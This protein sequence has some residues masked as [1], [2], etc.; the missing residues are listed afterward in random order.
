MK[1]IR[2][3]ACGR[4]WLVARTDAAPDRCP[5]AG[6][7]A[8]LGT[9][10]GRP[11]TTLDRRAI[12]RERRPRVRAP[13]VTNDP[14]PPRGTRGWIG[15]ARGTGIAF[16]I[17]AFVLLGVVIVGVV[18]RK[19]PAS[20]GSDHAGI[21]IE[22]VDAGVQHER[23]NG[24]VAR[25][26]GKPV[27]IT[28]LSNLRALRTAGANRVHLVPSAVSTEP[29]QRASIELAVDACM[30]RADAI[31][32]WIEGAPAGKGED[33]WAAVGRGSVVDLAWWPLPDEAGLAAVEV[34]EAP[35]DGAELRARSSMGSS[36]TARCR[37]LAPQPAAIAMLASSGSPIAEPGT[38]WFDGDGAVAALTVAS[39]GI[40]ERTRRGFASP[41]TWSDQHVIPL[42]G[43]RRLVD[44]MST[45]CKPLARVVEAVEARSTQP[46][47]AERAARTQ[48]L[49]AASAA[50]GFA[51]LASTSDRAATVPA[52][53]TTL[54][55]LPRPVDGEA[56]VI[57][58]PE[59]SDMVD[60]DVVSTDPSIRLVAV[61]GVMGRMLEVRDAGGQPA[62]L[63]A[64]R[65]VSISITMSL[66]GKP[67]GGAVR[68]LLLGREPDAA[69]SQRRIP[70]GTPP[71]TVVP[72]PAAPPAAPPT[73][74]PTA[75]PPSVPPPTVPAGPTPAP[76][77]VPAPSSAPGAPASTPPSPASQPS[78]PAN[79]GSTP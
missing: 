6:C 54:E 33:A 22:S 24:V 79:P 1:S 14:V 37:S 35:T 40:E 11:S 71:P 63:P 30:I 41:A 12:P 72:P 38:P 36:V 10:A 68:A 15:L 44:P 9:A 2:C 78:P 43:L 57:V 28:T 53:A 49:I 39:P 75:P 26:D 47:A 34:G 51:A 77:A 20:S 58:W 23:I 76:A 21:L 73:A 3:P 66:M 52:T 16:G 69:A 8:S 4:S 13:V 7:G 56:R 62:V 45:S 55:L 46:A 42:E 18:L 60:V 50:E 5:G 64:G 32:Q 74:P 59:L 67:I 65:P 31:D 19:L 25:I 48:W 70:G 17:V 27:A 29:G 61:P